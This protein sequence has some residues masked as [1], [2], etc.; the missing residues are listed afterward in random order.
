MWKLSAS[1]RATLKK[2]VEDGGESWQEL[3]AKK[4]TIKKGAQQ[5][6]TMFDILQADQIS[7]DEVEAVYNCLPSTLE[8]H[9]FVDSLIP[10]SPEEIQSLSSKSPED[11]KKDKQRKAKYQ[12][13]LQQLRN[14]QEDREYNEM[15]KSIDAHRRYGKVDHM[16][17]FGKEMRDVNRQMIAVVNT[18]ITVGGAFAFGFFGLDLAYP[19]LQLDIATRMLIGLVLGTLVFFADLYFIIKNMDIDSSSAPSKEFKSH[20]Q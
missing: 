1:E 20:K 13:R 2:V 5:L 11:E 7:C 10:L 9:R 4:V 18:L 16:E 19:H 14:E 15:T 6:K 8:F 3:S 17:S 12:A